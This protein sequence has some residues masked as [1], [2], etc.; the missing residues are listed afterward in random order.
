MQSNWVR[1][2]ITYAFGEE[3]FENRV[4]PVLVKRTPRSEIPWALNSLQW[5]EGEPEQ[6][7]ESLVKTLKAPPRAEAR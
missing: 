4:I 1:R 6:V 5:L 3:R 2:E 7:A